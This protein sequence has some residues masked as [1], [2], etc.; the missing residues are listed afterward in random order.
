[1][2]ATLLWGLAILCAVTTALSVW[3]EYS[4]VRRHVRVSSRFPMFAARDELIRLV[5]DGKLPQDDDVWLAAY[6]VT[7]DFLSLERKLDLFDFL[8]DSVKSRIEL[9]ADDER[10]KD[11]ESFKAEMKRIEG[12]IPEFGNAMRLVGSALMAMV[13]SRT[14]KVG[15]LMMLGLII[16]LSVATKPFRLGAQAVR[17]C[18]DMGRDVRR[19]GAPLAEGRMFSY[20]HPAGT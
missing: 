2:N 14:S 9:E 13:V 4:R 18:R 10:R 1:M 3:I 17:W 16:V 11:F 20:L 7:N 5:L 19:V 8:K 6:R 15:L 12:A